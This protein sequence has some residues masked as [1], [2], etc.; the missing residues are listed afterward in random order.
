MHFLGQPLHRK[1][2][3]VF[4]VLTIGTLKGEELCNEKVKNEYGG[5][6]SQ[7]KDISRFGFYFADASSLRRLRRAVPPSLVPSPPR[8]QSMVRWTRLASCAGQRMRAAP[9]R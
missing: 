9:T 2:H 5:D 4:R 6:Y 1:E 7:L 8:A 3:E